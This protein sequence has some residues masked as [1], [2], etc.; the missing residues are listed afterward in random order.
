MTG[1]LKEQMRA[2]QTRHFGERGKIIRIPPRGTS[3]L[4]PGLPRALRFVLEAVVTGEELVPLASSLQLEF[5][6][7]GY[8]LVGRRDRV[9]DRRVDVDLAVCG[10]QE[11]GVSRYHAI[12][13]A[14]NE[15]LNIKDFNSSNGT[16][17]NDFRLKPMFS[18]RLRHGDRVRFGGMQF[19]VDFLHADSTG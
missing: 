16:Y 10:G 2:E 11:H 14:Q 7:S 5:P 19:R 1:T 13:L 3:S 4:A 6:V 15:R 9:S 18:Y 17:L 8:M 12:I